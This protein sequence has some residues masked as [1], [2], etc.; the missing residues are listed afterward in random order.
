MEKVTNFII[1]YDKNSLPVFM[2][3]VN[4]ILP[5][6]ITKE[7]LSKEI[8]LQLQITDIDKISALNLR[9]DSSILNLV[10]DRKLLS[11]LYSISSSSEFKQKLIWIILIMAGLVI[12]YYTGVL[13]WL[14]SFLGMEPIS[15]NTGTATT[16]GG[17]GK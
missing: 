15:S 12:A 16:S 5:L 17:T 2:Y 7:K 10:Y 13:D 9:L 8:R 1:G 14:L 11:D 6:S 4:F 3:D